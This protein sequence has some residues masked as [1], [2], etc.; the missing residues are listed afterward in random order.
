MA[1]NTATT[2][3]GPTNK[4]AQ[5]VQ[6]I[7]TVVVDPEDVIEHLTKNQRRKDSLYTPRK[8]R[9]VG[10]KA[11]GGARVKIGV[12]PR[13]EGARYDGKPHP[14]WVA[15]RTFVQGWSHDERADG[16][17][18][19]DIGIPDEAENRRIMRDSTPLEEGTEEFEEQAEIAMDNW[20]DL[21]ESAV[22]NDLKDEI[23]FVFGDNPDAETIR[24]T[25]S[26]DY[27]E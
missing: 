6:Q 20:Q 13:G 24:H 8:F 14:V 19:Q 4:Q 10:F 7:D 11:D 15:P 22:R 18:S 5:L 27:D 9:L 1:R 25:V 23:E 26:V 12:D 3:G 2:D 21:F 16:S 17:E